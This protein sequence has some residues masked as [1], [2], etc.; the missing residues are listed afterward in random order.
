MKITV[1]LDTQAV[2]TQSSPLRFKAG[3]FNPIEIGFTRASQPAPLPDDAVVEF[4]LKPRNQWTGALLAYLNAFSSGAGNLYAGTLNCSSA[5]LLGALGLLDDA[6]TNDVGQIDASAEVTWSFSGHKFRSATLP[7]IVE[8]PITDD[9]PIPFP[10][11]ELYP[12]PSEIAL[13]SDVPIL[14]AL[15]SAAA[16]NAGAPN[17]A[18]TLGPDGKLSSNQLPTIPSGCKLVAVTDGGQRLTLTPSQVAVGDL[19]EQLDTRAVYQVIDPALLGQEAGYV[20]IGIRPEAQI[21]G[22]DALADGLLAYW[23]LDEE[24]GP[25]TDSTGN[26]NDLSDNNGVGYDAGKIDNAASFGGSNYLQAATPIL[27]INDDFTIAA[28][29]KPNSTGSYLIAAASYPDYISFGI[30]DAGLVHLTAGGG[31]DISGDPVP[32]DD[33]SMI[34][35]RRLGE[36][37]SVSVNAGAATFGM[38]GSTSQ[39]AAFTVSSNSGWEAFFQGL[40]DEVG[41]WNRALSDSEI[42]QLYNNGNGLGYPFA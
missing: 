23:K 36:S 12:P 9:N 11:P 39:P 14:P 20:K 7:V 24:S 41:V 27:G 30:S 16:L 26:G 1:N 8:S 37:I 3:C 10:D 34:V 38:L 42:T 13:K 5:A 2:I 15:G 35:A 32:I 6:P 22:G 17:G 40:I 21:S 25:R 28:W 19:V 4:A 29:V 31:S 18:A 33:W